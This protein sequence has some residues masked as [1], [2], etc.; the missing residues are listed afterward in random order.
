MAGLTTLSPVV[1]P[2]KTTSLASAADYDALAD[3]EILMGPDLQVTKLEGKIPL[4]MAIYAEGAVDTELEGRLAREALDRVQDYFGDTPFPQYTVQLELLPPARRSRLQFQP[5]A[6]RQ[7]NFQPFR[8]C[9]HH[10]AILRAAT[11]PH[12]V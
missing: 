6:C 7:R 11:V 4:V 8:G 3:S 1:P 9:R 2:P 10:R 5:G 12:A